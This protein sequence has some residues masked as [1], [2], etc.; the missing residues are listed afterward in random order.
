M[1]ESLQCSNCGEVAT[2]HLTQIINNKII[3]VDLCE[4]CA[5][6]KGVTDPEGFSLADLVH[7]AHGAGAPGE[8]RLTCPDCGLST[9]DFRRTGRLGCAGCFE[10]FAPLLRPALED[11][12]VG[13][14]HQGKVPERALNRQD[15]H[16]QLHSLQGALEDAIQ[17]EAYEEAAKLRDQIHAIES[18]SHPAEAARS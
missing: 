18:L 12:H 17:E 15:I 6:A 10:V 3:K 5:Q 9:A 7:K 1:A 11:M 13:S 16:R 2:V 8:P 14:Q 4:S